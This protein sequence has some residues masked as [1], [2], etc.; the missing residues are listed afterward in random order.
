MLVKTRGII[1]SNVKYGDKKVISK[2]Y[3]RSFGLRTYIIN[4][5]SSS[6]SRIRAAHIQPLNQVE[7]EVSSREKNEINRV[8]E[9]RVTAPYREINFHILKNCIAGFI[10]EALVK[11][12]KEG[13]ADED[14]YDFISASLYSLDDS[15]ENYNAFHLYFL[16][17]LSNYLGFFPLNNYDSANSIFNLSDGR[18]EPSAPPHSQYLDRNESSVFS[19]L[20]SNYS[21]YK[22]AAPPA[23]I[24]TVMLNLLLRYYH[25]HVPS[26]TDFKSL[27]VLQATLHG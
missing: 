27:P 19:E 25:F 22:E 10:N 11:T 26:F 12:L 3:T 7:L 1:L 5:S 6:K 14:L 16:M 15:T 2:I 18:F 8:T 13:D 4:F 23:G 17:E 24:R 21:A 9:I 20:I